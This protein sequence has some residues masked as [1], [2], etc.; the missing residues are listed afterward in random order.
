MKFIA[1]VLLLL[2]VFIVQ[3]FAAE[4][5]EE[6]EYPFETDPYRAKWC[7]MGM[8]EAEYFYWTQED[9]D[10]AAK[11]MRERGI[12]HVMTSSRAHFLWSYAAHFDRLIERL[13][14][15]VKACHKYGIYVVEHHSS[16]LMH[17]HLHP[18]PDPWDEL[19]GTERW[20]VDVDALS[21]GVPVS[22]LLQCSITTGKPL[23][24]GM[25]NAYALCPVNP[26]MRARYFALLDRYYAAGIDGIMTDDAEY[27]D[28]RC[29]GCPS[30]RKR[31]T[32][33]T[34]FSFP[35]PGAEAEQF[36]QATFSEKFIAWRLFRYR[37]ITD[38]HQAVVDHYTAAGYKMMRPNY[39]ARGFVAKNPFAY[40]FDELPAL[41]WGFQEAYAG[42]LR[43]S[44]PEFLAE[45]AHRTMVSL[46]HN[47]PAMSL[48]YPPNEALRD[49]TWMLSLY[50]NHLWIGD[51]AKN[52]RDFETAH[53][54][55]LV[56]YRSPAKIAVYDSILNREIDPDF[57]K[58]R[59]L[60]I[61]LIQT[62]QMKNIPYRLINL[63]DW[64][65][66][67][68][69]GI[70]FLIVPGIR[71]LTDTE[72]AEM[73]NFLENGGKILWTGNAGER[74]PEELKKHRSDLEVAAQ[75]GLSR[76]ETRA[77]GPGMF[78]RIPDVQLLVRPLYQL[79][80]AE[81]KGRP[82]NFWQ[83]P[84]RED[85]ERRNIIA[86]DLNL[87]VGGAAITTDAPDN[88]LISTYE[89]PETGGWSCHLLNC[90]GSLT[91]DPGAKQYLPGDVPPYPETGAFSITL[92]KVPSA[93]GRTFN[94][95][96]C[97]G[98]DGEDFTLPAIDDGESVRLFIPNLKRYLL[99]GLKERKQD[100]P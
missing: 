37:A 18:K 72:L 97:Y 29:C 90:S 100:T 32:E 41:D 68:M 86:R 49:F 7:F 85:E 60:G 40:V 55:W 73:K 61:G 30:C 33:E 14:M 56:R 46:Q 25:Y 96:V 65:S 10:N 4:V 9:F 83:P 36:F 77:V 64:N 91:P 78:Y 81:N 84:T 19:W 45:A 31:F 47:A 69:E 99:I 79:S 75:L 66:S 23:Q 89:N 53:A 57:M 8:Y 21:N 5:I 70:E 15:A 63:H 26:D 52:L 67:R 51:Y 54:D 35:A 2:F 76:L 28:E 44:W 71:F 62:M 93:R 43:Y 58:T 11:A 16:T 3:S 13:A 48:Y 98:I 59:D 12:T 20:T 74:D 95:A 1:R 50:S 92:A 27:M 87:V 42:Q 22:S 88:V 39:V 80:D 94:Q 34:G 17:N 82:L 38:F 6:A 24:I